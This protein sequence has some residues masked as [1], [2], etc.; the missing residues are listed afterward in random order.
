M[1][2]NMAIGIALMFIYVFCMKVGEVLGA[3]A[4]ANALLNVWFPNIIFESYPYIFISVQK[5]RIQNFLLLHLIVF[6]WGFTAILGALISLDAIPLVWFRMGLAVILIFIYL[7]LTKANFKVAPKTLLKLFAAGSIIAVHW[8]T[9][10]Q[11]IKVSNVSV[12]LITMSTGAFFASLI[13]PVFLKEGCINS[14]CSWAYWSYFVFIIFLEK[15]IVR[16]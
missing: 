5:T 6:I 7:S 4:G 13:E 14:R 9:F 2:V 15:R 12:A 1:G 8:V 11:A 3:V 10:F 16:K